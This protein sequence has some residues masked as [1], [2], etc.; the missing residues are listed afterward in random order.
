[1]SVMSLNQG[2]KF[3]L[4][5]FSVLFLNK[6]PAINLFRNKIKMNAFSINIR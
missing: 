1:M 3:D 4:H 5:D 2:L 6:S